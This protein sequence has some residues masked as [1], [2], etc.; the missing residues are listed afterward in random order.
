MRLYS[1]L[2]RLIKK[3]SPDSFLAYK[4]QVKKVVDIKNIKPVGVPGLISVVLPVFCGEK[5]L[6]FAIES[7]LNQSYENFELII[8]DDKSKDNSLKIAKQYAEKDKRIKIIKNEENLKLPAS[9]NRGFSAA[10]GEYYTW[11]S[12]DNIMLPNF[13][14]F[15]K[16][17]LDSD[18]SAAMVYAN[19]RLIDSQGK[20][21]RGKGWYEFP[22]FSGN[23]ILP[24]TTDRLN[25]V[26]NN[27]IGAAFMYRACIA[28]FIGEYSPLLFGIED[29][30]YWM[31]MNEV[32]LI[33]HTRFTEPIYMY[34][35]HKNSLTAKDE[36]LK[37]T[38]NRPH[39]MKHD[40]IRRKKILNITKTTKDIDEIKRIVRSFD[41]GVTA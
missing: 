8:V 15:M 39:L 16:A 37:I 23:V 10:K 3:N 27:T 9:L 18:K 26:A 12:H 19:M 4:N 1:Y 5:Y 36:E 7:V 30:D 33:R 32:F 34:R 13:L 14:A 2:K 25:D 24:D 21:L 35:F 31:R 41:I 17:E 38:E 20:I 22:Y 40:K 6:K 11:I 28:K 29:Y